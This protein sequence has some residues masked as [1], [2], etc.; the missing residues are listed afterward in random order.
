MPRG[1]LPRYGQYT[2]DGS[3][4]ATV[5]L[6]FSPV[7]VRVA[8]QDDADD[9]YEIYK[10]GETTSV[11]YKSI[12]GTRTKV[13]TNPPEITSRGFHSG[14]DA[15]LIVNTEKYDWVAF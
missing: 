7:F 12:A 8:N 14:T 3:N 5:D 9:F 6:G 15:D 2:G 13:T 10:T 11:A 4:A 1:R